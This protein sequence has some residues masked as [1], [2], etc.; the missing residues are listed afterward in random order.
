MKKIVAI[1]IISLLLLPSLISA[2][3]NEKSEMACNQHYT[4][5]KRTFLVF[6]ARYIFGVFTTPPDCK[7]LK[8]E[9]KVGPY[10]TGNAGIFIKSEGHKGHHTIWG[11]GYYILG[12]F[13][14]PSLR[15]FYE[16]W[17]DPGKQ[18]FEIKAIGFGWVTFWVNGTSETPF[19]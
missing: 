13:V 7:E 16:D 18:I 17:F 6:G 15:Y 3:Q 19:L 10:F 11:T 4:V 12:R 1:I 8:V 2:S 5:Y 14:W 9:A